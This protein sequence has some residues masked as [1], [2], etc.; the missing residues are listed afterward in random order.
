MLSE[1]YAY[2]TALIIPLIKAKNPS[3]LQ[4]QPA[5]G[6]KFTAQSLNPQLPYMLESQGIGSFERLWNFTPLHLLTA[7]CLH[8]QPTPPG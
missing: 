1:A 7:F 4:I 2:N 6:S 8:S 5:K 3:V